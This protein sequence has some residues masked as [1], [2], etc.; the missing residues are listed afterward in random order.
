MA[1]VK[2]EATQDG[3]DCSGSGI[4]SMFSTTVAR[5][6]FLS[7][8]LLEGVMNSTSISQCGVVPN[9]HVKWNDR[10]DLPLAASK[11]HLLL[12]CLH[13]ENGL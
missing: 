7:P 6:R 10:N 5:C 8:S 1:E 9:P 4:F 12:L 3:E 13:V 2:D 11:V